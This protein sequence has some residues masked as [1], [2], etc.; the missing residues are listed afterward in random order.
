MDLGRGVTVSGE[1]PFQAALDGDTIR[2]QTDGRTR[3]L[4]VT[5][6]PFIVRPQLWI[7]GQEWMASRTDYPASGWGS[8]R[9]TWLMALSIPAGHHELVVK[10]FRFATGWAKPWK[11]MIEPVSRTQP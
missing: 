4:Y 8:Y 6:P 2:I 1:A 9:N 3:V 10:D 11:P 7:D 5:Q